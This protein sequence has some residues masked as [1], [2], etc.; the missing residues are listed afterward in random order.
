[1]NIPE[2]LSSQA[3]RRMFLQRTCPPLSVLVKG[4][5][6]AENHLKSCSL[7]REIL[8]QA[9][10]CAEAGTLLTR[11]PLAAR[12]PQPVHAG[13]IRRVRPLGK[14]ETWFDASGRY[15]NPPLVLVLDE[16]DRLGFVR[17]A[18]VF[19][20]KDLSGDGDIALDA[21]GELFAET[22]NSYG[23][24]ESGLFP[25]CFATV[26]R[27]IVDRALQ[28]T[29]TALPETKVSSPRFNFQLCEIETGSFFSLE[30]NE[31]ALTDLEQSQEAPTSARVFQ[32]GEVIALGRVAEEYWK[33]HKPDLP[34]AA[35]SSSLAHDTGADRVLRLPVLVT[36]HDGCRIEE[37]ETREAEVHL[38]IFEDACVCLV[39]CQ[40]DPTKAFKDAWVE[41]NK[42]KP[43]EMNYEVTEGILSLNVRFPFSVSDLDNL[44][45]NLHI[46]LLLEKQ[47]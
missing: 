13:D 26:D 14:P 25:V 11:I 32:R 39:M 6:L 4:G 38:Y 28:A 30:L 33:E 27:R 21:Q 12:A 37:P 23:L 3:W 5:K 24:P 44:H 35:A 46:V 9:T 31:H 43:D 17:V 19:N 2:Q 16:P 36:V 10:D 8:T 7:C 1:M 47:Q 41:Y 22:W 45:N 29:E 20:E 15:H 18:Q 40:V 42:S 34:A